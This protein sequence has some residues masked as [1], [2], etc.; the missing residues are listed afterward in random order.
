MDEEK[1]KAPEEKKRVWRVLPH[2]ALFSLEDRLN[3]LAD[4]GYQAFRVDPMGHKEYL[5]IA[6][7]AIELGARSAASMTATIQ[8]LAGLPHVK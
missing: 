8:Q 1:D 7:D 4:N 5:I 6:F 2:V 3:E